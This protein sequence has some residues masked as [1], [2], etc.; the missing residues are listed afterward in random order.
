[1]YSDVRHTFIILPNANFFEGHFILTKLGQSETSF[2][3]KLNFDEIFYD[4]NRK[5]KSQVIEATTLHIP[6]RRNRLPNLYFFSH[7]SLFDDI[8][9]SDRNNILYYN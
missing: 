3:P 4:M 7:Q 6:K 1:M 9:I 5:K 2:C 8:I